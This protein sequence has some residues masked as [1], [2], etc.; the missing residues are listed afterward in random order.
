[1]VQIKSGNLLTSKT[2]VIGHQ[3]NCKGIAGGLARTIFKT[4]PECWV[5]YLQGCKVNKPL[6][7]TQLLR[8][9]DGRILANIFGQYEAGAATNYHYVLSG[10]KDLR[11]QM[12]SLHLT[13]LSLP[14][15]MGAGIGGGDWNTVYGLI[16]QVFGLS[17]IKVV[18]CKLEK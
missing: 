1:M 4:F 14:Y 16:E 7:K 9:N 2:Q 17:P 11:K 8:C 3:T 5:P 10:L 15:G 12:E 6:G 18:L 13:S